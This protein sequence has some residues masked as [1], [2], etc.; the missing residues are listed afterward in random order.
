MKNI[1]KLLFATL[2]L[3]TSFAGNAQTISTYAGTGASGS[4]GDGGAATSATFGNC[5]GV[6]TDAA[7]NLYITD[8]VNHKIRQVTPAGVISTYIGT[9]VAGY[10]GEGVGIAVAQINNPYGIAVSA[11]GDIYF[12]ETA[13]NRVRMIKEGAVKTIA[14]DGVPGFSGDGGAATAARVNGPSGI[15]ADALGNVYFSDGGNHRV[16]KINPAGVITTVAGNG[17]VTF[18]TDGLAATAT[19]LRFPGFLCFDP[20][21][22]LH[23]SV[24]GYDRILKVNSATG[25]ATVAAGIGSVAYTGDGGPATAAGIGAPAGIK[26]DHLGNL[27]IICNHPANNTVRKV[28]PAGIIST[29]CGTGTATSTGD[30]GPAAMA[31]LNRPVDLAIDAC[32]NMYVS[33][34]NGRKVRKIAYANRIPSFTN[35][36]TVSVTMCATTA[37]TT[38]VDTTLG[39][40]TAVIDSDFCQTLTWSVLSGPGHGTVSGFPSMGTA[41]GFTITPTGL[42]YNPTLGYT[43]FDTVKVRISDGV[44]NDTIT[45]YVQIMP[46]TIP[47]GTYSASLSNSEFI[48]YPNPSAGIFTLQLPQGWEEKTDVMITDLTGRIITKFEFTANNSKTFNLDVPKGT[49]ILRAQQKGQTW[50]QRLVIN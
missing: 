40:L 31:S 8:A 9:G 7:G 5:H 16:R 17:S 36:A 35:G 15:V 10:N 1:L 18:T 41:S 45:Y 46:C 19:P 50:V 14:G 42:A 2:S 49:Y 3:A 32:N 13:G 44:A 34:G 21:G 48:V 28:T 30:G 20:S 47:T 12:C 37:D 43:G 11:V 39:N 24:N 29:Y 33:E 4:T 22:N 38:T 23:I 26:F 27:Y 6:A 25:I